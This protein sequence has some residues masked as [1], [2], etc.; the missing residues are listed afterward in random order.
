MEAQDISTNEW[1]DLW[2]MVLA[3][4]LVARRNSPGKIISADS[5]IW[6]KWKCSQ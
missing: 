1:I 6:E 5:L 2:V 4:M 3:Q